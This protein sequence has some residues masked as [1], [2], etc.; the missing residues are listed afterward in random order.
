VAGLI[1]GGFG[2]GAFFFDYISAALV[3]PDGLETITTI[4][5]SG[6]SVELFPES[7]ANNVP[8]MLQICLIF[9]S[10]L[11]CSAIIGVFRN[12]KYVKE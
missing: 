10:I 2:F 8:H 6:N 12:P 9:W 7:V 5:A 1:I 4:D 3:N 11:C